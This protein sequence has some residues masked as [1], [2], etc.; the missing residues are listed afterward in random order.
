MI[1]LANI[2]DAHNVYTLIQDTILAIYGEF[3]SA[4][5]VKFFLDL[6]NEAA[7]EK[8]IKEEKVY[9]LTDGKCILATCTLDGNHILRLF[10]D[11][12][13]L[14]KG[15][16]REMLDYVES[17]AFEEYEECVLD[18]STPAKEFYTAMGYVAIGEE[19]IEIKSG[20]LMKYEIMKKN[21]RSDI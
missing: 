20:V 7:I 8:D 10:V 11:K 6:H 19:K 17:R 14:R 3:Y 21:N 5:E 15:Y 2:N 1:R 9:V 4:D 16:G 12:A 13:H 18:T